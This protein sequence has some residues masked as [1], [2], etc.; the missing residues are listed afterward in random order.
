MADAG[1]ARPQVPHLVRGP[2]PH[3]SPPETPRRYAKNPCWLLPRA[4]AHCHSC[5]QAS[6]AAAMDSGNHPMGDGGLDWSDS[7]FNDNQ[8]ADAMNSDSPFGNSAFNDF[9]NMGDYADSPG[10]L[11]MRATAKSGQDMGVPSVAQPQQQQ[12]K[13]M[14][15]GS[16]TSVDTSSQDSSS[17]SSSRRKRKTTSES[18]MSDADGNKDDSLLE[19]KAPPK[20]QV[21]GNNGKAQSM[22]MDTNMADSYG[23]DFTTSGESSPIN[24]NYVTSAL[25]LDNQIQNMNMQNVA[26][27]F[28]KHE[29][30]VSAI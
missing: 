25:S 13:G 8:F 26:Q 22:G 16:T 24:P 12:P 2:P 28:G 27:Q 7:I 18:P 5:A 23:F 17:D 3:A 19:M 4:R 21:F 1:V 15:V 9:T 11:Q 10:G 30:P 20:M 14:V 6:C 29:S